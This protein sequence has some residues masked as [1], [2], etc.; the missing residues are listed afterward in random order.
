MKLQRT[1]LRR[2]LWVGLL[3]LGAVTVRG[4][5]PARRP[6]VGLALGGGSA[7][8]IVHV[9]VLQWLEE[10]RVPVDAV[11]GTSM[12]ALIGGAYATGM[13]AAQIQDM[14]RDADWDLILRPDIPYALKSF[15]RKED[16]RGYA[17]KLEAGLRKGFRLQ[18]GL[19]PGHRIGLMLSRIALP[20]SMVDSFDDLPI[21]FRCVA[22]DLEKGGTVVLSR[23]PLGPALRA[24]MA[25]PGTFDPVRLSGRLLSD[26]GIL[27]NVPVDVARTMGAD[28]VIAVRVGVPERDK[29]PETIGAV[30]GRAIDLMMQDLERPRLLQADVV[31][32]AELDDF[33]SSDYRR[34]DELVARGY[35]AAQ[36][37]AEALLRHALDEDA[38][39]E[40][41][42]A[43]RERRQPSTG[44]FE[45]VEVTGVSE[46]A[47]AQLAGRLARNLDRA[48]D[49]GLIE[50]DLDRVIGLGRYASAMYD[51]RRHGDQEGLGVEIRDK[52]YAPP[53]V[54]FSLELDNENKDV[55]LSLGTRI[56]A[57]DV[58]SPGSELRVDAS[59]GS[60]LR[61]ASELLQPLGGSGPLRR[62]AFVAPRALY[63][64]TSE[65]LYADDGE[66]Q[67]IDSRQRMGGGLD[68]GWIIGRG[69][70]LRAGYEAAYVK[71]VTRV[72]NLPPPGSGAEHAALVRFD[73]EGQDRAYFP[74]RGVR[75]TSRAA[76]MFEAPDAA[77]GFG[78]AEAAVSAAW[79]LARG[80]HVSLSAEGGTSF[81]EPP[82][83]LY[84]FRLGGPFRVGALPPNG[85]RG[86]NL[87]LAGVGYRLSLGRMPALLG[88]RL[89]LTAVAEV[90]SVFD[91]LD[92][93]R[94]ESSLTGGLAADTLLGPVFV[95]A[96][97]GSEG[98]RAY[99]LVGARVR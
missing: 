31:V 89:Y 86:P 41:T 61:F 14:L 53:L 16:D 81:G 70:Q 47:A 18:S 34:S 39:A 87:L 59:L 44:P 36:E 57:M 50:S 69:T 10:H 19:N 94:F 33:K 49:P 7:K 42:R 29:P 40:H 67:A 38:W 92:G 54:K 1:R 37:Q 99:F 58:T 85:L 21:P 73:Y 17:I 68:L 51:R 62:G 8:G 23:G 91:E 95:G 60:T 79:R 83:V 75:L 90:G 13:S 2:A 22:T 11:A 46:A 98:V 24:S 6:R 65:N 15:R 74:S 20:Y 63:A 4:E 45:F 3:A 78:R 28:V 72:G 30:A 76:W 93:A 77:G 64:R 43:L 12:G 26:G 52:S 56:T 55:N 9:G 82:P 80:H 71:N 35:A 96:S 5:E 32:V 27:N 25:L 48:P 97:A 84:Q 88:D 66:L